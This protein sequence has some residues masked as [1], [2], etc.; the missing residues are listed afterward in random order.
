MFTFSL[1]KKGK[2]AVS[3]RDLEKLF[4]EAVYSFF[5]RGV[6][7]ICIAKL[8]EVPPTTTIKISDFLK[9]FTSIYIIISDKIL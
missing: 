1:D 4:F 6:N 7:K 2:K 8:K 3:S 9:V 5:V